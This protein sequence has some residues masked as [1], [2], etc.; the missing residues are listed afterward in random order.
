M[1]YNTHCPSQPYKDY[2][3]LVWYIQD[4]VDVDI[5]GQTYSYSK[6]VTEKGDVGYLPSPKKS[7]YHQPDI[8]KLDKYLEIKRR[9]SEFNN[10]PVVQGSE[11]I[12]VEGKL[13]HILNGKPVTR[14]TLSNDR[15]VN[16]FEL[17]A[18]KIQIRESVRAARELGD[19]PEI[20]KL[21]VGLNTKHDKMEGNTFIS[22]EGINAHEPFRVYIGINDK[23]KWLRVKFFYKAND[24][25]F[26]D[27]V[28]VASDDK[29]WGFLD[30]DF[31]KDHSGGTIWE[32]FDSSPDK[33]MLNM[34]KHI[35]NAD[36]VTFRFNGSKYRKDRTLSDEQKSKIKQI[37]EL[38]ELIER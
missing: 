30:L 13:T 2:A 10:T 29:R 26:I 17:D 36:D 34:V 22:A 18:I 19:S 33:D 12:I 23:N 37:L 25:L 31:E 8:I 32:W 3:G 9:Q 1:N 11:L 14:Y 15:E 7:Y 5:K 16:N 4:V 27:S 28:K 35:V 20:K 24:W 38:Y 21:L 6:I